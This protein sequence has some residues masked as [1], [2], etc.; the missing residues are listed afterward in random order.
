VKAVFFDVGETLADETRMWEEWADWIGVSRLTLLGVLGGVIERREHY[1]RT[2]E[3]LR[4]GFDV[5][6]SMEAR[7]VAGI[8]ERFDPGDLYPDAVNCLLALRA[9]GYV[10][11]VCGNQLFHDREEI[12]HEL[13]LPV[14][15]V[16]SSATLGAE[17]PAVEFFL[18][19][20]DAAGVAPGEAAYVGD[21]VDNDVLPAKRAGMT[22][23]FVHR[24]PW[25]FLQGDW[26]EAE[27][28]DIRIEGLDELPRRLEQLRTAWTRST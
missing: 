18:R 17:K 2:F 19:L 26:P 10:V 1:L 23:V 4:P 16:S 24:G 3:I 12:V 25:G 8:P 14:D 6:A 7:R 20:A 13:N 9:A 21:R 5:A 22:A 11:G 27:Q 15:L 28:A